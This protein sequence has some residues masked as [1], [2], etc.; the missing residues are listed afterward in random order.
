MH[1]IQIVIKIVDL[2]I[3]TQSRTSVKAD[4]GSGLLRRGKDDEDIDPQLPSDAALHS[5]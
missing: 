3:L 2:T 4:R 1:S 5:L